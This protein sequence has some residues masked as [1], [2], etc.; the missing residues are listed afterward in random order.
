MEWGE[1]VSTGVEETR[2]MSDSLRMSSVPQDLPLHF[3]WCYQQNVQPRRLLCPGCPSPGTSSQPDFLSRFPPIPSPGDGGLLLLQ[4]GPGN[5]TS[6]GYTQL[7]Q[8][9][10]PFCSRPP[11]LSSHDLSSC[12]S[13]ITLVT[14]GATLAPS[15]ALVPTIFFL[16]SGKMSPVCFN[17]PR[18]SQRPPGALPDLGACPSPLP[19]S[20]FLPLVDFPTRKSFTQTRAVLFTVDS[21]H[22][23]TVQSQIDPTWQ[24]PDPSDE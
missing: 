24:V 6:R 14:T 15:W 8:Q 12:I 4:S 17:A 16:L 7:T 18:P 19:T 9:S 21:Q 3:D 23:R 10:P 13:F 1:A 5:F 2:R 11:W 20:I 22:P